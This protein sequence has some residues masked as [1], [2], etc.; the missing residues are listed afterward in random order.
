MAGMTPTSLTFTNLPCVQCGC[1]SYT[2]GISMNSGKPVTGVSSMPWTLKSGVKMTGT[3]F[4]R[5]TCNDCSLAQWPT[6]SKGARRVDGPIREHVVDS[7]KLMIRSG[8]TLLK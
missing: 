7:L 6:P 5:L 4:T 1:T 8:W 3:L 2:W